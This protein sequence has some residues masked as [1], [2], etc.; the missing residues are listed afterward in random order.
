MR[1]YAA[2]FLA[3]FALL[4]PTLL[5]DA[6]LW[7]D[8][9][10]VS[11][12]S[13]DPMLQVEYFGKLG[14]PWQG[15]LHYAIHSIPNSIFLYKVL[16]ILSWSC[17]SLI[18]FTLLKEVKRLTLKDRFII[19]LITTLFP[20][21]NLWFSVIQMPQPLYICIFFLGCYL[22]YDGYQKNGSIKKLLGL[23]LII[24]TFA[25]QSLYVFI[26][27]LLSIWFWNT[28]D[29]KVG[30]VKS[31]LT[32]SRKHWLVIVFPLV[33]F[34]TL[35]SLFKVDQLFE[36]YNLMQFDEVLLKLLM[37]FVMPVINIPRETWQ[38]LS[39]DP[40]LFIVIPFSITLVL[41]LIIKSYRTSNSTEYDQDNGFWLTLFKAGLYLTIFALFPYALVN[42]PYLGIAYTGRFSM[43]LAL[44]LSLIFYSSVKIL[45]A[46][47]RSLR[48]GSVGVICILFSFL[49]IK[50]QI[51]WQ[52]RYIKYLSIV[53]QLRAEEPQSKLIFF[54]DETSIG[55][56][57]NL[58]YFELNWIM[59]QAWGSKNHFGFSSFFKEKNPQKLFLELEDR[60]YYSKLSN[61]F[62]QRLMLF[63]SS[64][65]PYYNT[66]A[67]IIKIK[68]QTYYSNPKL[69]FAWVT[70]SNE[71]KSQILDHLV[72][73][74]VNEVQRKQHRQN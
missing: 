23:L 58:I 1:H 44:P 36:N 68:E 27:G 51:L 11:S 16:S 30:I 57:A 48:A 71:R 32:F 28:R 5:G 60:H 61:P 38:S 72:N 63:E 8:L 15:W 12:W 45:F 49:T 52:V 50:D 62:F 64:A 37:S 25:L 34:V 19:S 2:L 4:T 74:E 26:Y 46:N 33:Q 66:I 3:T 67:S 20:G 18:I 40:Q 69:W 17:T 35:K 55:K 39:T 56:P 47:K 73:I 54:Q 42:K 31:A 43:L 41:P 24:P 70:G 65:L 14:M 21:Y 10:L 9:Y 53:N 59:Y 13:E 22:Y 7:D 6:I 29:K